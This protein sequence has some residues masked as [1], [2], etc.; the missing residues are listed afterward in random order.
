MGTPANRK[1]KGGNASRGHG[2]VSEVGKIRG[3]GLP[4]SI[5]HLRSRLPS[6]FALQSHL[7]LRIPKGHSHTAAVNSGEQDLDKA[8]IVFKSPKISSTNCGMTFGI[9]TTCRLL[10]R[11]ARGSHSLPKKKESCLGCLDLGSGQSPWLPAFNDHAFSCCKGFT[12][13]MGGV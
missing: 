13:A 5:T 10:I 7:R 12:I 2:G 3:C 1:S 6:Q 8:E 11:S 4:V 9:R